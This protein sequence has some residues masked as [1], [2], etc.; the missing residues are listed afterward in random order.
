MNNLL[1]IAPQDSYPYTDGGKVGIFFPLKEFAKN[2]NVYY[3][4]LTNNIKED[5]TTKYNKYNIKAVPFELNLIDNYLYYPKTLFSNLSFKFSKFY[6]KNFL[7]KLSELVEREN[8]E[9]IWI[10]HAQMAKYAIELK[11]QYPHLK[12]FLREHNIEYKLVKQYIKSTSNIIIKIFAFI[13]YCKTKKY[14][15]ALW[16]KFDKVFFISDD[17][18]N[19]AKKYN[20]NIDNTNLIYDGMELINIDKNIEVENNSFIFTGSLNSF[21]NEN[22]LKYF[23]KN[24]WIPFVKE[25]PE[26]K[27]YITGNEENFLMSKLEMTK[28]EFKQYN[29]INLGFVNNIKNTILSKQFVVSPTLYGSGIR[30]KVLE[31]LSLKKVVFVTDIDYTMVNCFKDM[32]NIVHYSNA[33]D[34]LQKYKMIKLN[35]ELY[36]K[37]SNNGYNLIINHLNWNEYIKR[38]ESQM[39][40]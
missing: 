7:D 13:E 27:F 16:N 35:S 6:N 29:I 3:A 10:C 1:Y 30:L 4:F 24:I 11:K 38:A 14:E 20:K 8:I 18:I 21:Q 25:I 39:N 2:F 22:N 28:F 5:I 26:A 19:T 33:N 36:S 23:I 40:V 15:I 31:S 9:I 34:F 32:E 17:D 37:I 12:I